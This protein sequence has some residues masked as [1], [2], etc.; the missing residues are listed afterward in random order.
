M[1]SYA[2][3]QVFARVTWLAPREVTGIDDDSSDGGSVTSYPFC[4]AVDYDVCSEFDWG[5]EKACV[6]KDG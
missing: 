4:G 6:K 3:F 1:C 5:D 2:P